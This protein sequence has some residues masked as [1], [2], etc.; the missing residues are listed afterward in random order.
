M[1]IY[2][3]LLSIFKNHNS[4]QKNIFLHT[5]PLFKQYYIL[6]DYKLNNI[7]GSNYSQNNLSKNLFVLRTSKNLS[8]QDIAE[9]IHVSPTTIARY[10]EGKRMPDLDTI[11]QLKDILNTTCDNLLLWNIPK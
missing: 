5:K 4:I 11:I 7:N 3:C 2:N 6:K 8:R 10:E 9:L 1:L